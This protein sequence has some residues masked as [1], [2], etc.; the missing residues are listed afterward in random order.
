[1]AF[2]IKMTVCFGFFCGLPGKSQ[3]GLEKPSNNFLT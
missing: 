3:M 1:M 2:S